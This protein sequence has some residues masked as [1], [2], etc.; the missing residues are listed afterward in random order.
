MRDYELVVVISPDIEDENVTISVD[1]FQGLIKEWGGKVQDV[2]NWGRRQLAYPIDRHKE[3][4]YVV[5]Q[6]SLPP[7]RVSELEDSLE[8]SE[9]VIRHLVVRRE[10]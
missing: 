3:G 7:D 10:G 6:F 5:A 8:R 9:E 4:N 1:R 2:D